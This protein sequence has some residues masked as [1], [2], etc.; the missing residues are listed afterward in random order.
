MGWCTSFCTMLFTLTH[1]P[2]QMKAA[3]MI[4]PFHRLLCSSVQISSV[5]FVAISRA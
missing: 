4:A 1:M 3:F 5:H 2:E